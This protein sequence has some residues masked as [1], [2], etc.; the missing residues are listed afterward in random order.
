MW[1]GYFDVSV[2]AT[3]KRNPV[4]ETAPFSVLIQTEG[5]NDR[6]LSDDL[7]RC[8][9]QALERELVTDGV[10][11]S[12][13]ADSQR[14]WELRDAI[15]DIMPTMEHLAVFDVGIPL[16]A[17]DRVASAIERDLG[18]E[19]DGC[20]TLLFGHIG[21]G[22][23]HVVASTGRAEDKA[24]IE[25]VVYRHTASANGSVSAEHGI[26]TLK[27]RWLPQSRSPA[28]IALMKSLKQA[29]DPKNI[30]NPGRVVDS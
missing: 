26:G 20:R 21:D 19:L 12:S 7:E 3:G 28:E 2:E 9:E 14:L 17:M 10:L 11:A 29:M 5:S 1:R 15:G 30:L 8:L 4:D 25:A 23:L 24:A 18:Q 6:S 16:A 22:N 13:L 27:K